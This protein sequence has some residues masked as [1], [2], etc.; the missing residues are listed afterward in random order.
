MAVRPKRMEERLGE[1]ENVITVCDRE[2][3]IFEFLAAQQEGGLRYLVRSF[4]NRRLMHS[5]RLLWEEMEHLQFQG[6]KDLEI[7]QR[8]PSR[9]S[10]GLRPGRTKRSTRLQIHSGSTI[11]LPKNL[12]TKNIEPITI[13]VV[14][15]KEIN[16]IDD[17]PICWRLLTSEPV[18]TLEQA[19]CV[20][21]YYE[22]R[23]QIEEFHKC[24]KSGL[25]VEKRAFETVETLE[26]FLAISTPI[27]IRLLQI[28][29]I[30]QTNPELDCASILSEDEWRCLHAMIHPGKPVPNKPPM[31]KWVYNSIAKLA[32]FRDTKG[33]GRAGWETIWHGWNKFQGFFLG[34]QAAKQALANPGAK[35]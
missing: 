2:A 9:G 1:T 29:H 14:Y 30:V 22:K 12:K 10:F 35:V 6:T 25:R 7:A 3:D 33:A 28:H 15:V 13:N 5:D 11:L 17:D 20:I 23:W 27:A 32:G 16:P 4:Q 18:D 24:W 21:G 19:L 34:W 31:T 8:G 26:R